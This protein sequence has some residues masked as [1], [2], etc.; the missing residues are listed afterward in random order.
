[1]VIRRTTGSSN[2]PIRKQSLQKY[3]ET[4]VETIRHG[5]ARRGF[6]L[7]MD[8]RLP[9]SRSD[10]RPSLDDVREFAA[11][12]SWKAR[13][14]GG[15]FFFTAEDEEAMRDQLSSPRAR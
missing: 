1:M 8:E 11:R 2:A 15:C 10:P 13:L 5:I 4:L 12:H 3:L 14:L 6:Y 7:L 9:I